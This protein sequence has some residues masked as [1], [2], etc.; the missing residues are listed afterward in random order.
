MGGR[1]M[2]RRI[3]GVGLEHISFP[4]YCLYVKPHHEKAVANAI[5][6]LGYEEFL[7]LYEARRRWGN[8]NR[9]VQM[10]LFPTYVFSQFDFSNRLPI[11]RIPGV[12]EII[13]FGG[14]PASVDPQ[15]LDSIRRILASGR[16]VGPWPFLAAGDRVRIE[17]GPLRGLEGI[18]ES[19][20]GTHRLILSVT[21]LQRS[22]A[23]EVEREWIRPLDYRPR[24]PSLAAEWRPHPG[25]AHAA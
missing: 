13:S 21:L 3:S 22:V 5:R 18:L 24:L 17:C 23:V 11:L 2:G 12:F 7:P 16:D 8:H 4:W 9:G 20:K 19:S 14:K 10:P 25:D 15:E 1:S 6:G